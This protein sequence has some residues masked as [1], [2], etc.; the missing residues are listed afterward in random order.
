MKIEN[1]GF[2]ENKISKLKFGE[3]KI[4][5]FGENWKYGKI[6]ICEVGEIKI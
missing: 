3:I 6:K 5:E 2:G 4:C 1:Y